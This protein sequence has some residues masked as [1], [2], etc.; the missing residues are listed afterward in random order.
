MHDVSG[1]SFHGLIGASPAML[2]LYDHIQRVAPYFR[3]ALITG[4]TGTG[5]AR[6]AHALHRLSPAAQGQLVILNCSALVDTLVESE[7]FGHVRGAFTGAHRDKMG[8]FE[9]A[10]R[11][12][13]FLDEIGDMPLHTQAKLLRVLQ[14]QEVQ[15]LGSLS[16]RK[17]D[18]RVIAATHRDLR[19]AV[20][21][22]TFRED[23]FYRLAMVEIST[24]SLTQR[25]DDILP[26]AHHFRLV[27]SQTF[28]KPVARFTQR[29]RL[30]LERHDWPGNVREL[31]NA[32][33][34]ACM[35]TPGDTID[36]EHLPPYLS[37]P[38]PRTL[39]LTP[40]HQ[41]NPTT[42]GGQE[43]NLIERALDRTCGN[44]SSA[45]RI[46][47]VSRDR[48]RYRMKKYGLL[49]RKWPLNVAVA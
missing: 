8:L 39:H 40:T 16:T 14:H 26:L 30:A 21:K 7:L 13:L 37:Q 19:E 18:V 17:V 35:L 43:R 46:L 38:V 24:P 6:V 22:R 41:H 49:D 2:Q 10:H 45:A 11:G 48:L 44:Q 31:E 9:F 5:K 1:L 47:G 28:G 12:V 20:A 33:G 23:L 36:L 34:L 25:T 32:I 42:L 27:F 15:R 29:A 3:S 4:P